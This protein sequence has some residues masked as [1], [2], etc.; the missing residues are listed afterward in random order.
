VRLADLLRE[1]GLSLQADQLLLTS[2]DGYARDQHVGASAVHVQIG[3]GLWQSARLAA[4]PSTDTWRQ[5]TLAWTPPA[6][7]SY[8][9][10]MRAT[11]SRHRPQDARNRAPFPA[12]ATGLH[13][14]T[15]H[16]TR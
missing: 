16:V 11:D 2:A 4:V 14:V 15:V 7:G 9:L 13:A 8:R 10:R 1:A 3:T 12:G 6:A 5:W